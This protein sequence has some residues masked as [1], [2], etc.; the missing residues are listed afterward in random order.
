MKVINLTQGLICVVSQQDFFRLSKYKWRVTRSSG[1][2]NRKLGEPYA[3]TTINKKKVYMHRLIMKQPL[4]LIVDH[5]NNQTLDNRRENL[6]IVDHKE[7]MNNR[8][9]SKNKFNRK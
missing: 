2:K 3:A 4:G 5:I 7:N 1:R 9:N 6:R 8:I